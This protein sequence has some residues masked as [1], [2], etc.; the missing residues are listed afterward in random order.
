MNTIV[1]QPHYN[2]FNFI[3]RFILVFIFSSVLFNSCES[4]PLAPKQDKVIYNE[5]TILESNTNV[6]IETYGRGMVGYDSYRFFVNHNDLVEIVVQE[7]VTLSESQLPHQMFFLLKL[8]YY[9]SPS[10]CVA[11]LHMPDVPEDELADSTR[12]FIIQKRTVTFKDRIDPQPIDE[13]PFEVSLDTIYNKV[14]LNT[15]GDIEIF[16]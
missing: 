16:N 2:K 7:D 10:N 11:V 3:R 8:D 1:S 5:F 14:Y 12:F 13:L 9:I 4:D 6:R 15:H